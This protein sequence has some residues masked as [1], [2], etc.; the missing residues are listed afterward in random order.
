MK[1]IARVMTVGLALGLAGCSTD[2]WQKQAFCTS[3]GAGA[4]FAWT[5]CDAGCS[6]TDPE[7]AYDENPSTRTIITPVNGQPSYTTMLTATAAADIPAGGDVGVFLTQPGSAHFQTMTTS[8]RT[9]RDGVEQETIGPENEVIAY[10]DRGSPAAGFLGM[11]TTQAFDQVELSVTVTWGAG[12]FPGY[13][14]YEICADG[15]E[16]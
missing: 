10:P 5:A 12:Q 11:R 3:F 15:G 7:R 8:L 4:T 14:V 16:I 6:L 2:A 1:Q 13:S 9:I